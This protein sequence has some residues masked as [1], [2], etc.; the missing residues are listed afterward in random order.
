VGEKSGIFEHPVGACSLGARKFCASAILDGKDDELLVSNRID[1]P[2]IAIADPIE[3]VQAFELGDAGGAWI[4]PEYI[5]PFHE[6]VPKR[7]G[8][9]VKLLLRRRGQKNC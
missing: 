2:I 3:M 4:S 5:E 7:F 9:C 8:E 6:N 1:N